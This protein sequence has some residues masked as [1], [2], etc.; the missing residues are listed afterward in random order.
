MSKR[1]AVIIKEY[2]GSVF[3]VEKDTGYLV[4]NSLGADNYT[5]SS[6]G[7]LERKT[8]KNLGNHA[9]KQA[10]QRYETNHQPE[11]FIPNKNGGLFFHFQEYSLSGLDW[12]IVSAIPVSPLITELQRMM[13][14]TAILGFA[15][16][17]FSVLVFTFVSDKLFQPALLLLDAA[18]KFSAGD[19]SLRAP[20]IRKNEVG[21]LS[22]SFNQ[23]SDRIQYLVN[24]LERTV[25]ARTE[26]LQRANEDL[27]EKQNKISLIL[28]GTAE[29]I[30][31]VDMSAICT[32]CNE[33]SLRLLGYQKPEEML[34]KDMR[35]LT[36]YQ[37]KT[38]APRPKGE[39]PLTK[40]LLEGKAG[41][42]EEEVLWRADG[43]CF[44]AEYRALPQ[45]KDGLQ[46]GYI[47]TFTDITERKQEE[48]QIKYLN[49]HDAMTGL[50]NR[51]FFEEQ[52]KKSED[53]VKNLPIS[54]IIIDLNGLK[55]IN[56]AFGHSSGDQLIVAAAEVLKENCRDKDLAA[57]IG[58]DE[59]AVL[60]PETSYQEAEK[61]ANHI[62]SEFAKQKISVI[63]GSMA[64]GIATKTKPY[65]VIEQTLELAENEMYKEKTTSRQRF[66]VEAIHNI[67]Q[68]LH[69]KSV[70]EKKHSEEVGRLCGEIGAA[71]ELSQTEIRKLCDAGYLHDIGKIAVSDSIL[72]ENQRKLTEEEQELMRQHPA[73]GYRILNSSEDLLDLA[74]GVYGHHERWDGSGYPKGLAGEEI[75]IISRIIAVAEAFDQILRCDAHAGGTPEQ[76]LQILLEG[77]GRH[78]DPNITEVL[79]RIYR[80]ELV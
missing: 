55:M 76:A 21:R 35:E 33:S 36:F 2:N 54:V 3:I 48:D 1:L 44:N 71:M 62:K 40:Y 70:Y 31:G 67:I 61:K 50:I 60:L 58:G 28:N 24:N 16:L 20:V 77:A 34:G 14:I 64:A 42:A 13:V 6:D 8:Y 38:G 78:F 80:S 27:E 49:S 37:Y 26:E 56:D 19:L 9:L 59:F 18:E 43:T 29:G 47:I 66:G 23:V 74:D 69:E 4:A 41:R 45:M 63:Y 7:T 17:L 32:F 10:Y 22:E 39:L 72:N 5:L 30:F 51:R 15:A 57:R 73:I 75:P 11:Q 79:S 65:Q 52:M 25:A 12:M 53:D 46:T 68:A